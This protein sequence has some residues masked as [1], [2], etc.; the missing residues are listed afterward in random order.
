M[1]PEHHRAVQGMEQLRTRRRLRERGGGGEGKGKQEIEH[2][3]HSKGKWVWGETALE[4]GGGVGG[5]GA[6]GRGSRPIAALGTGTTRK[7]GRESPVGQDHHHAHTPSPR[8][9][10][11]LLRKRPDAPGTPY[12]EASVVLMP[13]L[14]YALRLAP[15]CQSDPSLPSR[16]RC[17]KQLL[18]RSSSR[19]RSGAGTQPFP[20]VA[21][22]P[23]LHALCDWPP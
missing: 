8:C 1:R 12:R 23:G 9:S 22:G 11:Q 4:S 7:D 18:S 20:R 16:S 13:V 15:P 3:K 2:S 19:G 10:C 21:Q 14:V 6:G 17:S 5:G